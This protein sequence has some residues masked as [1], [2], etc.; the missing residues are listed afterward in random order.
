MKK[1]TSNVLAVVLSSSFVIGNAQEK[2]KD[3]V[4]VK[5]IGEVVITALGIKRDNKSLGYS[6]T[7]VGGDDLSKVGNQNLVNSLSGKAAGLQV[8]SS[9][10]APGSGSRLVIRGGAKSL[11]NSNEPLYVIDGVPITNAND[12][13]SNTVTGISSPNRAADINPDDIES[14]NI[15][16]GAAGAVLYGNRGSNGVILITTKSGKARAGKPQ[17]TLSTQ[18]AVDNALV[19]PDYQTVYAQGSRG[20][21]GEGTSYSWGPKI[22][23]QT[24]YSEAAGK[25]VTLSVY[26]PRKQFLQTGVTRNNNVS[27]SHSFNKSNIFLS[28]GHSLQTSIVPNQEYEKTNFRFN[29]NTQVTEKFNAGINVSYNTTKGNVPFSGQD[30]NNPI[31]ALFHTP[32]SWD[33]KGYG[34][35]NPTTGEQIN[36]RGG[37]FDNP[38]WSVYKNSAK[39]SSDRFIASLNLGY[40][41]TKWLKLTYRLGNDYFVDNRVIFRD[42]YSGSK[43]KGYLSYD[44]IKR[45]ELTSTLMANINTNINDNLALIV[46]LGQDYNKRTQRNNIITGTELAAPGLVNTNNIATSDPLY[47]HETKRTL[48]GF[49]GDVSLSYKN[50][51]F[52]D[53]V[54]RYE[55]AS[56]LPENNRSYFYPGVSGSF[57]FSDAFKINKDILS[58]GKV[59]AG[60][61]RTARDADPYL[62]F[63]AYRKAEYGD[64]FVPGFKFPYSNDLATFVGYT[65]ANTWNNPDLKPEFTTEYEAGTELRFLKNRIGLEFTYFENKN[66]DGIINLRISPA[67]GAVVSIENTGKT[68][69]KGIEAGLKV[70]PIKTKDFNWEVNFNFSRIRSLV[71]E[72]HPKTDRIYMGGFSGNPA[73]YAVKGERYGSIVGSAYMRDANGNI[74]VGSNGKPMIQSGQVLGHVEPDWT[75]SVGTSFKYKGVYLT[76]QLDIRQGGYLF[77]GT[78]ELLDFYGV[79]AKTLEREK[80][81]IVF[82]GV[83]SA[84]TPNTTAIAIDRNYYGSLP[85]EAYV[86]KNDWVKLRE[87]SLGYS[88]RPAGFDFIRSI[89]VGVFGRNLFL[90]TKVPHIDPESSSFGTGNAQGVSRFAF[91]STRSFG[92]NL[93]VQF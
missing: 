61:S 13:N 52:L 64:G 74:L 37:S 11:T 67:S 78:E 21:Y 77:N 66:T 40:D 24:V 19:L 25:N 89:D 12:G 58:Y 87:I 84:G 42:I 46:I 31:F 80:G 75:G 6:T 23:G 2:P 73:I 71:E 48:F 70:T 93:K 68:S 55:M 86:Y 7:K 50:Y 69:S 1:L 81:T 10:G 92:V 38:Y 91:P 88:F 28:A 18:V 17:I 35:V 79:S 41:L 54:G 39:T 65:V 4:K 34:Y 72:T 63:Q 27:L 15:L 3:S 83:T 45:N 60:I 47:N 9:G 62:V 85:T 36:F 16:K 5:E 76:A 26:D 44:D 90:W 43:P 14:I 32:V 51:L 53:L 20:V 30:G 22:Q 8:I 82:P 56:T 59:R 57:I 49:F 33:L 29:G